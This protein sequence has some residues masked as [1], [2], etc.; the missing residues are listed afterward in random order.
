MQ[1]LIFVRIVSMW[2]KT[3]INMGKSERDFFMGPIWVLCGQP[4][5]QFYMGF[6]YGTYMGPMWENLYGL[7]HI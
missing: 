6:L 4:H 2:G 7:A 5:M 1:T 3:G